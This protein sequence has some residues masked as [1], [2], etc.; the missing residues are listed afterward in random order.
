[1]ANAEYERL[2]KEEQVQVDRQKRNEIIRKMGDILEKE[3]PRFAMVVPSTPYA[4][5]KKVNGFWTT[6]GS[7]AAGPLPFDDTWVSA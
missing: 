6:V 1:M 2:L 5:K 3:G 7:W 4:I